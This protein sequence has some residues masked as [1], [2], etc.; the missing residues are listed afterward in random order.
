MADAK[1]AGTK[2]TMLAPPSAATASASVTTSPSK[3]PKPE[4]ATDVK[5]Q[6]HHKTPA[7]SESVC[8]SSNNTAA[9][10]ANLP[11]GAASAKVVHDMLAAKMLG[12]VWKTT[13]LEGLILGGDNK[14]I[15]AVNKGEYS[16]GYGEPTLGSV[17]AIFLLMEAV[18]PCVRFIDLGSGLGKVVMGATVLLSDKCV[19]SKGVEILTDRVSAA[20]AK[21]ERAIAQFPHLT[22]RLT[23]AT[24]DEGNI[25]TYNIDPYSHIFVFGSVFGAELM[26]IVLARL[27]RK[28]ATWNTLA[29][30]PIKGTHPP[31]SIGTA[32]VSS[33]MR[34]TMVGCR[35]SMTCYIYRRSP[36]T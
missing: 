7:T 24:F 27:S 34:I 26:T 29:Y 18:H 20:N 1:L 19:E 14:K 30:V 15:A 28:E 22:R 36:K 3:K 6:P 35:E 31:V 9:A 25:C 12:V 13:E 4:G 10:T 11:S 8:N 32:L 21:R 17:R 16:S 23:L 2:H 5:Y 33:S